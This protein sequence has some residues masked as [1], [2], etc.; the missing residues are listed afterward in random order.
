MATIIYSFPCVLRVTPSEMVLLLLVCLAVVSVSVC[1]LVAAFA[2]VP[3]KHVAVLE[4]MGQFRSVLEPGTY[5]YPPGF[6]FARRPLRANNEGSTWLFPVASDIALDLPPVACYSRD[7]VKVN[8]DII[9]YCQIHDVKKA[10]YATDNV[11][12]VI[13]TRIT[14]MLVDRVSRIAV[15]DINMAT[16][17]ASMAAEAATE[18]A[19]LADT[20][21]IHL[22]EL[23]IE[24]VEIPPAITAAAETQVAA[25]HRAVAEKLT[26]QAQQELAMTQAQ[27]SLDIQKLTHAKEVNERLHQLALEKK[28]NEEAAA[29]YG[30]LAHAFS[31]IGESAAALMHQFL[32]VEA[33]HA[34]AASATPHTLIVTD[35]VTAAPRIHLKPRQHRRRMSVGDG[36]VS[37]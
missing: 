33:T 26:H 28:G 36:S 37:A 6:T 16:L 9:V 3:T 29:R 30:Q 25:R 13:T 34:I 2:V 7:R 23:R 1:F 11:I 8:V 15:D 5:I 4:F 12:Q 22:Q 35:D 14:T 27:H 10:V 24:S 21:G 31:N 18:R 20:Y 32:R 17:N 19:L